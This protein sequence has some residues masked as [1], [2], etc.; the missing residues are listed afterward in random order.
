MTQTPKEKMSTL[1]NV[2]VSDSDKSGQATTGDEQN[3]SSKLISQI[4]L[5]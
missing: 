3:Y 5:P 2:Q 1:V 4:N